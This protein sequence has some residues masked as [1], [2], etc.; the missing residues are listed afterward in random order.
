MAEISED[1]TT[2]ADAS[3]GCLAEVALDP[4]EEGR[5]ALESSS[6]N[7]L[8]RRLGKEAAYTGDW[9]LE[10]ALW[11]VEET[12][13]RVIKELEIAPE[14]QQGQDSVAMIAV[15][16][17][18]LGLFS[19]VGLGSGRSGDEATSRGAGMGRHV[20]G[21]RDGRAGTG[22][23]RQRP[24]YGRTVPV[25]GPR[26]QRLRFGQLST[27]WLQIG[28]GHCTQHWGSRARVN[29]PRTGFKHGTLERRRTLATMSPASR[30]TRR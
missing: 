27:V 4:G 23:C 8:Q 22:P 16:D 30:Q 9:L 15:R 19:R 21:R 29:Q 28:D 26:A 5:H 3:L 12:Q 11:I 1:L 17:G 7:R 18:L 25:A 14:V 13:V 2:P 6:P 24:R 20:R 10:R